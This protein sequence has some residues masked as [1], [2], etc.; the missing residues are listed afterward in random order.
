MHCLSWSHKGKVNFSC[1]KANEYDAKL[2]RILTIPWS[3]TSLPLTMF[4][5]SLEMSRIT[6]IFGSDQQPFPGRPRC[7][8]RQDKALVMELQLTGLVAEARVHSE[9][10]V[11]AGV[12]FG[13]DKMIVFRKGHVFKGEHSLV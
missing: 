2:Y 9:R 1:S 13:Q 10:E 6:Q 11:A 4:V 5:L 7:Y 3:Q 12:A 8:G